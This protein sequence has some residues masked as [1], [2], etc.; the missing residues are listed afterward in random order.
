MNLFKPVDVFASTEKTEKPKKDV[1]ELPKR[2][3]DSEVANRLIEMFDKW[4][5]S[6]EI[7]D[8][9]LDAQIHLWEYE[10]R[11][12]NKKRLP[13]GKRGTKYFTP[14]STNSDSRELYMK[15]IKSDRDKHTG[16]PHQGRWTRQGT[17]YGDMV[18]R[19]LLFIEKHWKAR[20]GE[21]PPFVPYYVEINGKRYPAWEKFSQTISHVEH[22]GKIVSILGQCDGILVDTKTGELVLLEIKSKQTTSAQTGFYSMKEVK[23]DHEMQS[24]TYSMLFKDMHIS[25]GVVLYGN[26]SKKAWIMSDDDCIANPDLRG[27]EIEFKPEVQTRILDK[28]A[29]VLECV[30]KKTP[31]KFDITKFTFNS[32][33]EATVASLTAEE[34]AEVADQVK[35]ISKSRM[36]QWKKNGVLDA[37]KYIEEN[38]KGDPS[39]CDAAF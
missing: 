27:F 31:P 9:E 17:A 29:N 28:F 14:S 5:G 12:T 16:K 30:D 10:I 2:G 36:P 6:Q 25:R 37:W 35:R 8:D 18:Q 21:D 1:S 34:Y 13:W 7:W 3:G 20:F 32:Y 39:E 33:K 4:H 19:D 24:I 22:N 11:T 23:D 26:L 38:W 15:H